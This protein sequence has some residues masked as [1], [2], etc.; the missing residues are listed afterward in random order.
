M[1]IAFFD[2]KL[3]VRG[4]TTSLWDYAHYNETLLG[5]ESIVITRPFHLVQNCGDASLEVYQKFEARFRVL[6]YETRDDIQRILDKEKPVV[7]YIIKAGS[8]DD[9]LCNFEN[10]KT[11]MH[12]VFHP[13]DPHGDRYCV[14]SQWLNA[15]FKRNFDV[16]P[17]MVTLPEV[18]GDLREELGIPRDAVVFGRHGGFAEFDH[19]EAQAAVRQVVAEGRSNIY[20]VFMNTAPFVPASD[21]VIFLPRST[22]VVYKTKFINTCDAMVYGRSRGET[23]GLAIGEFSIRNK[24][25]FAALNAPE[26][27]HHVILQEKGMW[28]LSAEDLYRKLVTFDPVEARKKD[29]NQ[30]RE[31]SPEAVMLQFQM[32]VERALKPKWCYVTALWD[33]GDGSVDAQFQAFE[34]LLD[35]FIEHPEAP[36]YELVI[37]I[38]GRLTSRLPKILPSHITVREMDEYFLISY[39][40][41]WKR[42]GRESEIMASE[43]YQRVVGDR[44]HL[45]RYRNP[46]HTLFS[47]CKVEFLGWAMEKMSQ[48]THFAWVD[49]GYC[50]RP[51]VVPRRFLDLRKIDAHRVNYGV[52]APIEAHV[53]GQVVRNLQVGTDKVSTAFFCGSREA[54]LTYRDVYRNMHEFLQQQG[55]ADDDQHL[56]LLCAL[57]RP[58]LFCMHHL[59][60]R[61]SALT[62]FQA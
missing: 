16:I 61:K 21:H 41:L 51:D 31:Y 8:S 55:I 4:T 45:P 33:T 48:A 50:D 34:P 35:M 18:D 1:R 56:A 6:Y 10:V 5:N 29:W 20:F 23:F 47:H 11:I 62:A 2:N 25:V 60:S 32:Q 14:I 17:H 30:Y 54:L 46:R 44:W 24:P 3:S 59:G 57:E 27:M 53:D 9:G 15:S 43:A 22:D 36:D 42:M 37:F 38:D 40:K 58:D 28:Y 19:P 52:V 7:L 13:T 12:C 39:I 49:F 26:R